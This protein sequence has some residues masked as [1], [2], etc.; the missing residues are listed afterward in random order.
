MLLEEPF[1][2]EDAAPTTPYP[3][4]RQ[5]LIHGPAV[6]ECDRVSKLRAPQDA[7]KVVA[8]LPLARLIRTAGEFRLI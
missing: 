7:M 1:D 2:I 8:I 4:A 3:S 6:A 5:R